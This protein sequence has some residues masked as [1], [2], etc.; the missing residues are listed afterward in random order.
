MDASTRTNSDLDTRKLTLTIFSDETGSVKKEIEFTLPKW[1]EHIRIRSADDKD[2]LRWLKGIIFGNKRSKK[3]SFRTNKNAQLITA[4]V[5]EYDGP[6][7]GVEK[8]ITFDEAKAIIEKARLRA[9]FY[10]SPSHKEGVPRWR[11]VFPLS[12]HEGNPKARHEALV[13][14]VNGLFTGQL[15]PE[16]FTLSQSYYYGKVG[17]N[18]DHRVEIVD[19]DFLN[20][21]DDLFAGRIYKD[22]GALPR[23]EQSQSKSKSKRADPDVWETFADSMYEPADKAE[24]KF[25]LGKISSDHYP[26]WMAVGAGIAD[27]FG[28]EGFELFDPWSMK[29]EKY[30]KD[31]CKEKYADFA[32]MTDYGI[33]TVFHLA[34]EADPD[35]REQWRRL[36]REKEDELFDSTA[37]R[38]AAA[39]NHDNVNG[40]GAAPTDDDATTEHETDGVN[41]QSEATNDAPE[42]PKTSAKPPKIK[43]TPFEWIDPSQIPLRQWLYKPYYIRQFVSLTVSTGGVGKSSQL[44]AEALAMVSG[45]ELLNVSTDGELLRVWYW[46]GEDPTDELQRRFAAAIKHFKLTADDIGNRLFLDSGRKMRIVLAEENKG[47]IKINMEV[48][49][50]IVRTLR[51]NKIDVLII[52][53]HIASHRVSENDNTAIERVAKAWGY[54][55]EIANC[56]IML[57]HHTRKTINGSNVLVEDGRG[58]SAL[59][60]AVRAA[61]ALNNMTREEAQEIDIDPSQRGFYFRSDNGKANLTP[62]AERADWFKLVSVDLENNIVPGIPGDEI[63]VVTAWEYPTADEVGVSVADIK[64]AQEVIATGGPWRRDQRTKERW[65]GNAIAYAFNRDVTVKHNKQWVE[66]HIQSWL[67]KGLLVVEKRPDPTVKNREPVG[68]VVVGR[69]PTAADADEVF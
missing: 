53:P 7:N 11:V 55:A 27:E 30:N 25:A 21:R 69:S 51:E 8:A 54:I 62:P 67:L 3:N 66:K 42:Q 28:A 50:D 5:V 6:R 10:T 38:A 33:G 29:S 56:A 12:R 4:I 45:K 32:A 36:R 24:V 31:E 40:N 41:E 64:H 1:Q 68:F 37:D 22:G 14:M 18:P 39:A 65:I 52:D 61:R 58:A 44:I 57:A 26:V 20:I 23:A 2:Q 19:G 47:D 16:S 9:L 13:A 43:A 34:T 46:N 48:I 60:D 15:A 63:G 59:R 35:W 49:E 17:D